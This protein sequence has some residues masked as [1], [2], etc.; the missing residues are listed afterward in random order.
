MRR[1]R[2]EPA[3]TALTCCSSRRLHSDRVGIIF[4]FKINTGCCT[5]YF[6]LVLDL[7]LDFFQFIK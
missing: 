2:Q 6:I 7:F 3:A 4:S 1:F 5:F